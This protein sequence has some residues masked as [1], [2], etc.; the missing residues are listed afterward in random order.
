MTRQRSPNPSPLLFLFLP[1]ETP[2]QCNAQAS[3]VRC[4]GPEYGAKTLPEPCRL[5]SSSLLNGT[6]HSQV[7]QLALNA[8]CVSAT[9]R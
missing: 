7:I 2:F 4:T 6:L 1:S 3:L 8:Y 9:K 5:L